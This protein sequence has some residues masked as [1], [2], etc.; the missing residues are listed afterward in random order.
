MPRTINIHTVT[1]AEGFGDL[2]YFLNWYKLFRKYKSGQEDR[3]L[4][5]AQDTPKVLVYLLMFKER[6]P[7]HPIFK[8][9]DVS[10]DDKNKYVKENIFD[11]NSCVVAQARKRGALSIKILQD[12]FKD[13]DD[14]DT[15]NVVYISCISDFLLRN[16][17]L[18]KADNYE[19]ILEFD[20]LSRAAA[21]FPQLGIK[22]LGLSE[23]NSGLLTDIDGITGDEDF[24]DQFQ[25]ISRKTKNLI[26]NNKNITAEDAMK[27][28]AS[29][30]T[31]F[32]YLQKESEIYVLHA[33]LV[34]PFI[35]DAIAQGKQPVFVITQLEM[36][37]Q[38]PDS[39][40]QAIERSQ[41]RLADLDWLPT[42]EYHALSV[43]LLNKYSQS[44]VVPSGDTSLT[45]S[46][47]ARK[48]PF[49]AHLDN[50]RFN[51]SE[52]FKC[53]IFRDMTEIMIKCKQDGTFPEHAG[54]SDCYEVL[55]HLSKPYINDPL[56]DTI[57]K[58]VPFLYGYFLESSH[59]SNI[60]THHEESGKFLTKAALEFFKDHLAPY[61]M[62]EYDFERRTLPGILQR[63]Y[64]AKCGEAPSIPPRPLMV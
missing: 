42:K 31:V 62:R 4:I 37:E 5:F 25:F 43:M 46:I 57:K 38:L 14:N 29:T 47:K 21:Q 27:F 12:Y 1:V 13:I 41:I 24:S 53:S 60:S 39:I 8:F 3:I 18:D 58:N 22:S 2:I 64:S 54:F 35:Q 10:W 44:V 20:G 6:A 30:P 50:D 61:I 49:Y 34:S 33:L 7:N 45:A 17:N 16:S 19:F 28:L 23:N 55:C 63:L 40:K 59:K 32:A 9:I 48:L 11:A 26:F 56:V 51:R 15:V 36:P 52:G